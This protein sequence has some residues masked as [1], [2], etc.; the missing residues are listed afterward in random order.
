M[1]RLLL[2]AGLLLACTI[3]DTYDWRKDGQRLTPRD[4][5]ICAPAAHMSDCFYAL[6]YR[7]VG[8][9]ENGKVIP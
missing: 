5:E 8:V 1:K 3:P 2:L 7:Y 4:V 6:G 9:D